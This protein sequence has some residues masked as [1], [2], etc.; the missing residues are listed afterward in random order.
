[1]GAT[2][3]GLPRDPRPPVLEQVVPALA[4]TEDG[5]PARDVTSDRTGKAAGGHNRFPSARLGLLA[6]L[7]DSE[8]SGRHS[9]FDILFLVQFNEKRNQ[10]DTLPS[11]HEF[12]PTRH[13]A[14]LLHG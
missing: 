4:A 12:W 1:V 7:H 2:E 13:P 10:K 11:D 6:A 3:P 8:F 5:V 14:T 9:I